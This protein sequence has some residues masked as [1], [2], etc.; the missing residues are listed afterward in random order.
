MIFFFFKQKTAYEMRISDW[1]SDV[2]SSDLRLLDQADPPFELRID[3]RTLDQ[4][5]DFGIVIIL[6]FKAPAP[7]GVAQQR[8]V[9][10]LR[11]RRDVRGEQVRESIGS[12]VAILAA[13]LDRIRDLALDIAVAVAVLREVAVGALHPL[14]GVDVHH[15]DRLAGIR[16]EEHTSELQSL[17]RT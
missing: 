8:E 13:D 6:E 10:A 11:P 12:A 15:M 2:C 9:I 5:D 14:F 16:S 7:V 4:A 1:S 3:D 17:M